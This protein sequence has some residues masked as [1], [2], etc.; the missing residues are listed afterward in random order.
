MLMNLSRINILLSL[1]L[2]LDSDFS[3]AC[4]YSSSIGVISSSD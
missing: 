2:T 3:S 4:D 1:L